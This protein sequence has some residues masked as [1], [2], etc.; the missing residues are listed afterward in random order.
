M[1]LT[2]SFKESNDKVDVC[3]KEESVL[4]DLAF[5]EKQVII[6]ADV[7][8]YEGSYEVDPTFEAQTLATAGKRMLDDLFIN[9][10]KV[11][12]VS[13]P[14]GGNTVCIGG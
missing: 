1:N 2:L 11:S 4:V 8:P 14:F 10:I 7:E 12:K 3:F 5:Q 6:H 9:E 13:N